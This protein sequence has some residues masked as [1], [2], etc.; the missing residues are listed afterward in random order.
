MNAQGIQVGSRVEGRER[1]S[2]LLVT[3]II[4]TKLLLKYNL[5]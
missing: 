1:G 2:K 4:T 5:I 3:L